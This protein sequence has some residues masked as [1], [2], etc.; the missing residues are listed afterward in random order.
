VPILE[1]VLSDD[2]IIKAGVGIDS[3]LVQL[4]HLWRSKLD[5]RSRLDLGGIGGGQVTG[6]KGL[7]RAILQVDLPKSTRLATSNWARLPLTKDQLEYSARDAWA[8]AAIVEE[9]AK[10]DP[11]TF[12]SES[13]KSLLQFQPSIEDIHYKAVERK[14]ARAQL[15]KLLAPFRE[16]NHSF[17]S[18]CRIP[19]SGRYE[20]SRL[21]GTIKATAPVKPLL[22]DV[23]PLGIL[24][25]N[26]GNNNVNKLF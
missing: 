24:I 20:A 6:L 18:L 4:R 15:T 14:K 8:G 13:L 21:Q 25:E 7:S 16:K 12:S 2:E 3:D 5:A 23:S 11:E 22:F 9:L 19:V 26:K 17:S 1:A 10:R